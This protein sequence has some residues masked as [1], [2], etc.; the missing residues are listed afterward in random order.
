MNYEFYYENEL[1]KSY[2]RQVHVT[3]RSIKWDKIYIGLCSFNV[4]SF[5]ANVF[6]Y[7]NNDKWL[8]LFFL[9]TTFIWITL[10]FTTN[11]KITDKKVSLKEY[12]KKYDDQLKIVDY[13]KYLKTQRTQKLNKI[14]KSLF[15]K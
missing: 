8:S 2:E 1:L 10:I 6:R 15:F 12:I 3:K 7:Y 14:K 11:K 13:P 4:L 5:T 9:I